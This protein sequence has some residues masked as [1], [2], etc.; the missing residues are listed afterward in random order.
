MIKKGQELRS[1]TRQRYK[2]ISAKLM[3]AALLCGVIAVPSANPVSAETCKTYDLASIFKEEFFPGVKWDN[4]GGNRVITWTTNITKIRNTPI[5]RAMSGDELGWLREAF[6]SWDM[7]L[8]TVAFKEVSANADIEVGLTAI[9]NS[10]FWN[11]SQ[12]AGARYGGSIQISTSTSLTKKREGF[13]EVAQSEI[14]NLLG[15]GDI[16][17]KSDLDSVMADPDVAPFGLIPLADVDIDMMRQ[18][19]GESTCHSSW[20]AEL[21]QAKA[22]AIVKAEAEAKAKAEA[23]AKAAADAVAAA[24]QREKDLQAALAQAAADEKALLA[25]TAKTFILCSKNKQVRKV[26]GKKAKCPSGF[27]RIA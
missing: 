4:S 3:A 24:A 11:V 14:G 20:S 12:I 8:D 25:R 6:G 19:Y 9:Q 1:G 17:G 13:I 5:S 22:D 16:I 15:L 18:F 21:K 10:G 7:A 23:E 27:K 2:G 26:V